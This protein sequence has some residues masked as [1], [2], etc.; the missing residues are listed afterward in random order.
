MHAHRG[1]GFS[2]AASARRCGSPRLPPDSLH[3]LFGANS[4]RARTRRLPS[5]VPQTAFTHLGA[6]WRTLCGQFFDEERK[7]PLQRLRMARGQISG[8]DASMQC[9]QMCSSITCSSC[10]SSLRAKRV[11]IRSRAPISS[12]SDAILAWTVVK[13]RGRYAIQSPLCI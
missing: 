5:H 10:S 1:L 4:N 2:T 7:Q 3:A 6:H 11:R 8:R 9:R 12:A 13:Y